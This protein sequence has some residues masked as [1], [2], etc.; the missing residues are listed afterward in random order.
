MNIKDVVY[1]LDIDTG[2]FSI[3][4]T[5]KAVQTSENYDNITINTDIDGNLVEIQL[6]NFAEWADKKI[7]AFLRKEFNKILKV[8]GKTK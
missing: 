1:H 7:T 4:L 2:N 3:K 5:D 8:K 6:E